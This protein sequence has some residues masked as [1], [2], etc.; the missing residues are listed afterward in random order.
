MDRWDLLIIAGALYVAV[1]ALVRLMAARRDHLVRQVRE[2]INQQRAQ[3]GGAQQGGAQ[4]GGG[5][6]RGAQQEGAQQKDGNK[7]DDHVGRGAA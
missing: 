3:Q 7:A 2:Q 4:Q 5:Q 1:V 6:Q